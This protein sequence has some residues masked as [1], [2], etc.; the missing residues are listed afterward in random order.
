MGEARKHGRDL[1]DVIKS[2]PFYVLAAYWDWLLMGAI[3]FA[4]LLCSIFMAMRE[5]RQ[6]GLILL[7]LSPHLYS[8][9]T[10]ILI[11][12]DTRYLLPSMFSFLIG[13]GYVLSRGWRR[14]AYSKLGDLR[15]IDLAETWPAAAAADLRRRPHQPLRIPP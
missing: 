5:W 4:S 6:F 15:A 13:L 3:G 9:G 1:F 8:I 7:L 12:S 2:Q 14:R 11:H 10:H